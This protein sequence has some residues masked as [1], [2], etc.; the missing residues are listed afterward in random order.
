VLA[1]G[2]PS[3]W[4]RTG[5]KHIRECYEWNV[6]ILD[7]RAAIEDALSPE[8]LSYLSMLRDHVELT[9]QVEE[10]RVRSAPVVP[11]VAV[12]ETGDER[13]VRDT[14]R[15]LLKEANPFSPRD[16]VWVGLDGA[17]RD[18]RQEQARVRAV[19]AGRVTLRFERHVDRAE[20]PCPGIIG[21]A[22]ND[23]QQRVQRR[24]L[25]DLRDGRTSNPRLLDVIVDGQYFVYGPQTGEQ[26]DSLSLAQQRV[27]RCAQAVEDAFL[28]LGPPGTGKTYTIT[29][30]AS[31]LAR[32]GRRVLMTSKNNLA[33][34]NVLEGLDDLR[35]VRLGSDGEEKLRVLRVGHEDVVSPKAQHLLIDRQARALQQEIAAGTDGPFRALEEAM[36]RWQAL[37]Q[38]IAA[39]EELL[40]RW[41]DRQERWEAARDAVRAEQEAVW[42][43]YEPRIRR[44]HDAVRQAHK[45]ALRAIRAAD[46]QQGRLEWCLARRHWPVIGDLLVAASGWLG[47]AERA[48]RRAAEERRAYERAALHHE[49]IVA[50]YRTAARESS[51]VMEAKRRLDELESALAPLSR[52]AVGAAARI[53][54]ALDL[55]SVAV[56]GPPI[57]TPQALATTLDGLGRAQG[58]LE[59]RYRL[60]AEW[61]GLLQRRRRALYPALVESADVVGATCIGIAT[62]PF[63]RDVEFDTVIADEAGQIQAFDLLVPLVRAQ[64]AVLVGDH[65]QLPPVVDQDVRDLVDDDDLESVALLEQSLFERLFDRAPETHKAMLDVQFRMPAT[66][67]EFIS[68]FFYEGRYRSH[69]SC[70]ADPVAPFFSRPFCF[71]DTGHRKRYRERMGRGEDTGYTNAG[72]A[73]IL[74]R[75]ASAYLETDCSVGVIVPYR[76]QVAEVR[77]I[78][79]RRCPGLDADDLRDLVA[80]VD[81]F[82]GKQRDVILFGF[83]RSNDRG[84]VG[85]LRELRRLNVT[86]TRARRQL[87]LVGDPDTLTRAVDRDFRRF[88]RELL[89]YVRAHGQ[90]LRAE[91]LGAVLRGQG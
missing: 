21:F 51:P 29:K 85:F 23:V 91:E 55:A 16:F 64:R 37:Q 20:M 34:D 72:E 43:Q 10:E 47:L 53:G 61:R 56:P 18:G 67:A 19:E 25:N 87:V 62:A 71:V 38:D 44:Q 49:A 83:T 5:Y 13:V 63:M 70:Q 57:E 39:L 82:Q 79:R 6:G 7:R 22:F 86:I 30:L 75:L 77:R 48:G 17:N 4:G 32:Q 65:K 8:H 40:P 27:V 15:F 45:T 9:R 54:E 59:W 69:E 52:S 46:R 42:R 14:Y 58:V 24:A 60:L 80:T 41:A 28:V 31:E 26:D 11:Y 74:A 84:S 1:R 12:E 36:T 33:V 81:S 90:V 89:D 78:L 2:Q 68:D 35:I 66:I 88:A 50:R 3:P 73:S 76:L